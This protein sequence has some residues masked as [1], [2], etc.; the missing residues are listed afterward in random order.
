METTKVSH[1][2]NIRK[3]KVAPLTPTID[4][5]EWVKGTNLLYSTNGCKFKYFGYMKNI[6]VKMIIY[7][8]NQGKICH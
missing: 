7:Q 6:N 1:T 8:R 5:V 4:I 2:Y 3:Y